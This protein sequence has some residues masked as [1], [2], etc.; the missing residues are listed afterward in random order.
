[1]TKY[2]WDCKTVDV[3]VKVEDKKDVIFNVHW[4]LYAKDD[5]NQ[6]SHIGVANLDIENLN[7]FTEFSE[8][9][10]EQVIAWVESY[11]GE[12]KVNSMKENL[13]E[14]LDEIINPKVVRKTIEDKEESSSSGDVFTI[15][16]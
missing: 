1:M 12:D 4:K 7:N 3:K 11:L 5:T 2:K 9:T 15:Q 13:K 6:V 16:I 14:K 10:H 8:I